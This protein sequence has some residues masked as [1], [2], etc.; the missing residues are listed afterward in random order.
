MNQ[1]HAALLAVAAGALI[2][3][4]P[5]TSARA[6]TETRP[7]GAFDAITFGG[8]GR[9]EITVGQPASLQLEGDSALLK[10]IT[11]E[12]SGSTLRIGREPGAWPRWRE[13]GLVVRI[14]L[15][16]L[17]ALNLH[18]SSTASVT[19]LAGD[20]TTVS[21]HGS[22]DL[23]AHGQAGRLAVQVHGSGRADLSDVAAED[24]TVSI[25]GSGD[26]AV[27]PHHSLAATVHGSGLVTYAGDPA[28][29]TTNLH[30]S[31]RI[32]RR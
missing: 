31:G 8:A 4:T 20:S 30:G 17:T 19:G 21:L 26:V 9:I 13:D 16:K 12:I 24:A 25:N 11:T 28:E 23:T 18:G 3:A 10:E 27:Q 22:N 29:V 6:E 32:E 1:R 14:S 15:P 7:V 2:S 5:I